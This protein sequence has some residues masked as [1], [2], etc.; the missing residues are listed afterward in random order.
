MSTMAEDSDEEMLLAC[1]A[2]EEE[3]IL[4]MKNASSQPVETAEPTAQT[5]KA[6]EATNMMKELPAQCAEPAAAFDL[7]STSAET[8]G[9][10]PAR[11]AGDLLPLEAGTGRAGQQKRKRH[12]QQSASRPAG[13]GEPPA[14]Q[15]ADTEVSDDGA[16]DGNND[17]AVAFDLKD[18]RA[19]RNVHRQSAPAEGLVPEVPG[20][21]QQESS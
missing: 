9:G 14:A 16:G 1:Q 15:P 11:L 21:Y 2:L 8:S 3:G 5:G 12:S 18:V 6:G 17:T 10:S 19:K 13:D 4:G 20:G 7:T